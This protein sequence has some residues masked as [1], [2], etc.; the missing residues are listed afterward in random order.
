MGVGE[1]WKSGGR[2]EGLFPGAGTPLLPWVHESMHVL[3]FMEL[4]YIYIKLI[5]Y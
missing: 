5:S 1:M 2:Q 3:K 4:I